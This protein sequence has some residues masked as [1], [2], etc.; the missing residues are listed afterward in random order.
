MGNFQQKFDVDNEL[1]LTSLFNYVLLT[2]TRQSLRVYFR[3]FYPHISKS[4]FICLQYFAI[5][6]I[7]LNLFISMS[8][9]TCTSKLIS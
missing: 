6:M 2:V 9:D 3:D 8:F 4:N 5:I 7:L 1:S